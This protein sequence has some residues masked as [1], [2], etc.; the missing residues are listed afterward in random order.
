MGAHLTTIITALGSIF[1]LIPP[2]NNYI[3]CVVLYL[4]PCVINDLSPLGLF[5][6]Y[7]HM[8]VCVSVIWACVHKVVKFLFSV[9][10]LKLSVLF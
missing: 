4:R 3:S 2:V 5:P 6:L 8:Y 7:V 9:K 10:L 1:K